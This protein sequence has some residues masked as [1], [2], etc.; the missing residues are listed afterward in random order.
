MPI[1]VIYSLV[2]IGF[3]LSAQQIPRGQV[4]IRTRLLLLYQNL[5]VLLQP[6]VAT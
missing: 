4:I 1:G 6:L 3:N 2:V 5:P